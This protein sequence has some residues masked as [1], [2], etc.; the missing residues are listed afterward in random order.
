MT[1]TMSKP[2]MNWLQNC[3]IYNTQYKF[4]I[5]LNS[6][7]YV[8]SLRSL[9]NLRSVWSAIVKYIF[10]YKNATYVIKTLNTFHGIG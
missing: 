5:S 2:T 4:N 9:H 3:K 1:S 10:V 8:N 6:L 7:W